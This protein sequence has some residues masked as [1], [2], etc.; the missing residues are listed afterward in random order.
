VRVGSAFLQTFVAQVLQSTA[1]IVTTIIIAR[2][3][4][5]EGQGRY[6]I[7]AA[8]VAMGLVVGTLGQFESH[9]LASAG[10]TVRGRVLI[11]RSAIHALGVGLV[12]GAAAWWWP[13]A[14]EG[15]GL[16]AVAGLFALVLTL[17]IQ[18]QLLRGINLGQHHVTG[19]NLSSLIQRI[20][21]L[22][23]VGSLAASWGIQLRTVLLGWAGATLV[24]VLVT[25]YWTWSRSIA[26]GVDWRTIMQGWHL[27]LRQ[28]MRAL[29]TLSLTIGLLRADIWMLGALSGVD[30]VGQMSVAVS[31]AEWLWYVPYILGNVL[32]AAV[33]A[34]R[35]GATRQIC[36]AARAVVT[37]VWP[38][39][40]GLMLVGRWVVPL[41]YGPAY[42]PAGALFALLIPGMAA[43]AIHI[44]VDSYFAGRGFPAISLWSAFG[45]LAGKVGL[46]LLVI[47]RFGAAGAA[48]TTSLIYALLLTVKLVAFTRE[49][50]TSWTALLQ[51]TLDETRANLR[52]AAAWL[53]ERLA[54]SQ[55]RVG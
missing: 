43:I 35:E 16:G 8:A 44:V 14:K 55:S 18:A 31:L 11:V 2:G 41:I 53:R 9:V 34:D 38:V 49:T 25:L 1:S 24:S 46:N 6:A 4:G 32:F 22:V 13:G 42:R 40:V 39:A 10:Q 52:S 5:P 27:A 45:A 54:T 12:L 15:T 30:T 28:G 36:R 51:P 26:D 21:Y 7:F 33:A 20:A 23:V 3:L 19:Y 17:E 47:P 29:V 37:L 48:A 50:G